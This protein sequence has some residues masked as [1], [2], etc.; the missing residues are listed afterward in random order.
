[1]LPHRPCVRGS[2]HHDV[3]HQPC[4]PGGG[5]SPSAVSPSDGAEEPTDSVEEVR[6][7]LGGLRPLGEQPEFFGSPFCDSALLLDGLRFHLGLERALRQHHLFRSPPVNDNVPT[8]AS[9]PVPAPANGSS[10]PP[11]A[12][13]PADLPADPERVGDRGVPRWLKAVG[14]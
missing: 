7:S 6:P 5:R 8:V 3:K 11:V 12:G 4:S 13:L 14:R 10:T 2:R 1:M 9:W